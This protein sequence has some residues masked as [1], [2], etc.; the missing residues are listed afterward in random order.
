MDAL[1]LAWLVTVVLVSILPSR[2]GDNKSDRPFVKIGREQAEILL[3]AAKD[4]YSFK[5]EAG[6]KFDGLYSEFKGLDNNSL[7][8]KAKPVY[9]EVLARASEAVNQTQFEFDKGLD[10]HSKR[11]SDVFFGD[12]LERYH[13]TS[14][15]VET[16]T[17][18]NM[19]EVGKAVLSDLN[20][21]GNLYQMV[22]NQDS[23]S[24]NLEVVTDPEGAVI[25][26]RRRTEDF[27]TF[28]E[29]SN[30]TIENLTVANWCVHVE[31]AGYLSQEKWHDAADTTNHKVVFI[32]KESN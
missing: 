20:R 17:G 27:K 11:A 16:M 10:T 5:V 15:S 4:M 31:L 13:G 2:G 14:R 23:L 18:I 6:K 25:K 3:R 19:V 12:I 9:T 26:Y 21:T 22:A 32:F 7:A 24:F 30:T 28:E 1:R 29:P 8:E